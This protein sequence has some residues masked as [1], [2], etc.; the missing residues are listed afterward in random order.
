MAKRAASPAAT[1]WRSFESQPSLKRRNT[2]SALCG[3]LR[4]SHARSSVIDGSKTLHHLSHSHTRRYGDRPDKIYTR[5]AA[6]AFRDTYGHRYKLRPWDEAF[7]LSQL[8]LVMLLLFQYPMLLSLA[9][10]VA[11]ILHRHLFKPNVGWPRHCGSTCL[12]C[13]SLFFGLCM[14]SRCHILSLQS[15]CNFLLYTFV[16]FFSLCHLQSSSSKTW[17]IDGPFYIEAK[18]SNHSTSGGDGAVA[19]AITP[20]ETGTYNTQQCCHP[21][22][23]FG[24][25]IWR[26]LGKTVPICLQKTGF[27]TDSSRTCLFTRRARHQF[28]NIS[29]EHGVA[30]EQGHKLL[31]LLVRISVKTLPLPGS[32]IP[33]FLYHG[34]TRY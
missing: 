14:F 34:S 32:L 11:L 17:S 19:A 30:A 10:Y 20:H 3:F 6:G 22:F 1:W 21:R 28:H 18:A 33:L 5:S 9:I 8:H 26:L 16:I 15:C 7:L 24:L 23:A 27:A 4:F 13:T 2:T 25:Q 31:P 12:F 29:S